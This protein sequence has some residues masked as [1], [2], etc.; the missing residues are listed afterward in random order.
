MK[1]VSAF[2]IDLSKIE[3]DGAFPCPS[4]GTLI[5]PDDESENTYE[6]VDVKTKEDS[7]IETLSIHCKKCGSTIRLEGFELLDELSDLDDQEEP[8]EF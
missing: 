3:G 4:C 7:L 1:Q 6:I 5:S 8:E 2:T